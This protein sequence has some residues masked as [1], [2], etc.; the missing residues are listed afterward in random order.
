MKKTLVETAIFAMLVA[1]MF[2]SKEL[3]ALLPNIHLIGVFIVAATIAYRWKALYPIYG[4]VLLEG[5]LGGFSPWW[6]PYLYVWT[7]LWAAAMF[8]PKNLP[9]WLAPIICSIVCGLHGFCYG[10]LYAPAQALMFG[11]DFEGMV[12]WVIAGI[13]P[14]DI[15]HGIS[16]LVCGALLIWPIAQV[17]KKADKLAR[18]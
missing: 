7:V 12:A 15:I 5:L 3:M 6:V 8:I 2:G 11:L 9:K 16:N 1:L 14:F 10:L 13:F 18:N 17:L 4:F